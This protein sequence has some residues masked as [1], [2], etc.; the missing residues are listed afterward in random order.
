MKHLKKILVLVN[1]IFYLLTVNVFALV[2]VD[3]TN[4][5]QNTLTAARTAAQITN[6]IQQIQNQM[7]MLK[8]L[9]PATFSKVSGI[10]TQNNSDLDAILNNVGDI[11]FDLTSVNDQVDHLYNKGFDPTTTTGQYQSM[12]SDWNNNLLNSAKTSMRSQSLLTRVKDNNNSAIQILSQSAGSTGIVGQL[13]STNQMIGLVSSGLGNLTTTLTASSRLSATL[14]A[15][16]Y[17]RKQ[18]QSA[19]A[20]KLLRGMS[21]N[22][23]TVHSLTIPEIK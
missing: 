10:Y 21:G 8:Q 5:V 2:V 15:E 23:T 16:E 4:L 22:D 14:A 18:A 6:Q 9:D 20:E 1:I 3:Y 12:Y 13:Q 19:Y 17:S 11:S 7:T